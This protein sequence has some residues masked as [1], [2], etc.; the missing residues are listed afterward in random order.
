MAIRSTTGTGV[1]VALVVFI[2]I[3]AALLATTIIFYSQLGKAKEEKKDAEATL[4][5]V[6]N[7]NERNS[8]QYRAISGDSGRE[9]IFGYLNQQHQGLKDYVGRDMKLEDLKNSFQSSLDVDPSS[10][11]WSH[12]STVERQLR[13]EQDT[14]KALNDRVQSLQ[15]EKEDMA[16][17]LQ[18]AERERDESLQAAVDRQLDQIRKADSTYEQQVASAL[19]GL[20][21]AKERNRGRYVDQIRE[22]EDEVDRLSDENVRGESRIQELQELV[23]RSRIQPKDPANL[24][25]GEIIE[26]AGRGDQVYIDRGKSDQI[27]LGMTFEVYDDAAQIRPDDEGNFPRGKA[28]IQ[29]V[30]VGETTSTAKVTRGTKGRPIVSNDVVANAIYDPTY[31]FKFLVHGRFDVDGDEIATLEETDYLRRQIEAWGGEVVSGDQITGDLDFLVLGIEPVNPANPTDSATATQMQ[32]T[33][34]Q[35]LKYQQYQDLFQAAQKS[36]IPVL[37]S[38][39]L[40]ILTG[41]TGM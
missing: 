14:V 30:K 10:T 38:N 8:D 31:K 13:E 22:L 17:K 27:V 1:V 7:A 33:L 35:R 28:S 5:D 9:S 2:I 34:E 23:N 41:Q 20:E 36:D 12:L 32:Q 39:R 6:A 25:D 11:L 29:V 3:S 26:V 24:V 37:N 40:Y 15:T 18:A 19:D 16:G 4:N 21:K